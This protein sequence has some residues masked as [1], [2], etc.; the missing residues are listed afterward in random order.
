MP[1]IGGKNVLL[2]CQKPY[3]LVTVIPVHSIIS[4]IKESRKMEHFYLLFSC[5]D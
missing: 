4:T 3:R 5:V 2:S 1:N